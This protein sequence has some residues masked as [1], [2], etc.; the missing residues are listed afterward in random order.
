MLGKI[1]TKI[2]LIAILTLSVSLTSVSKLARAEEEPSPR[3]RDKCQSLEL[4]SRFGKVLRATNSATGF[5]GEML[6]PAAQA[7]QIIIFDFT[8]R[9]DCLRGDIFH[10]MEKIEATAA[11]MRS[12]MYNCNVAQ[13]DGYYQEY[14]KNK[15]EVFY[16][17]NFAVPDKSRFELVGPEQ[18]KSKMMAEFKKI[19]PEQRILENLAEFQRY[20]SNTKKY[21]KCESVTWKAIKK[22]FQRILNTFK[23]VKQ[24]ANEQVQ[25]YMETYFPD[26]GKKDINK[27]A[28]KEGQE[29]FFEKHFGLRLKA[30]EIVLYDVFSE[31]ER[32][33]F[34]EKLG[35]EGKEFVQGF[36]DVLDLNNEAKESYEEAKQVAKKATSIQVNYFESSVTSAETMLCNIHSLNEALKAMNDK[37]LKIDEDCARLP[38]DKQCQNKPV[39]EKPLPEEDFE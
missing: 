31:K 29:G 39:P 9:N 13:F 33:K 21:E 35:L 22:K 25:D 19:A 36:K 20:Y 5:N 12:A 18:I 23:D 27:D 16:L 24:A 15:M 2:G 8:R 17:R 1:F 14:L 34:L 32:E 3:E 30:E 7:W 10:A 4:V 37:V 6:E 11:G 38:L 26:A 28:T